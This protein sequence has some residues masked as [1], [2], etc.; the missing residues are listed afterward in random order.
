MATEK[1]TPEESKTP[2]SEVA[3][4]TKVEVAEGA[5]TAEKSPTG[6]DKGDFPIVGIGASAGG[7]EAFTK[8]LTAAPA[9]TGMAFVLIQHLDPSHASNMVDL[10]KRYTT[11]PVHEATDEVK[12]E[13]DH[14][15]MIPPNRNMTISDHTLRL[16]QQF[17]R[18]GIA[19]SIDL[20]FKSL[21]ADLREKAICVIMSGTGTDGTLGAKAVKAELGL[22][23]VQDPETAVYDGMPRSAIANGVA[24]FILPAEAMP[25]QLAEYAKKSFGKRVERRTEVEKDTTTLPL[26]LQL[27]RARTRGISPATSSPPSPGASNGGWD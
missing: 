16:L 3:S 21:A 14:V 7:L 6:R 27:I 13:P 12:L 18:P 11:M 9:A 5:K 10:L 4:A 25:A 19:H 17:E 24:D 23:I 22:V 26:V 1:K 8:F 15:Y 2:K 20:F